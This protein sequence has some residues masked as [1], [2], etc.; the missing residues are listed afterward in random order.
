LQ[1]DGEIPY[2]TVIDIMDTLRRRLP[3][4]FSKEEKLTQVTMPKDADPNDKACKDPKQKFDP[5]AHPLFPDIL[6]S[7]GFE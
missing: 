6:F 4:K 5:E 3:K 1:A 2:E 7:L